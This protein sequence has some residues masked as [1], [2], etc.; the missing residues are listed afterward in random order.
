MSDRYKFE[1]IRYDESAQIDTC[2]VV[3]ARTAVCAEV[4]LSFADFLRSCGFARETVVDAFQRAG[5]DLSTL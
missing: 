4:A 2:H 3:K 1:M 5:D